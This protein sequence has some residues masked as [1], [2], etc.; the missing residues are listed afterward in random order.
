VIPDQPFEIRGVKI[1]LFNLFGGYADLL[2]G[3]LNTSVYTPWRDVIQQIK[4]DGANN[5]MLIVS[6][7]VMRNAT[8][9]DFDLSLQYN[10]EL[11]AVRAIAE[12]VKANGM[13]VT[14]STFANVANV[15]SGDPGNAGQDRPYPLDPQTWLSHYGDSIL[16][17]ARFAEAVGASSFVPFGDETQHLFR[18]TSLTDGWLTLIDDIRQVFSGTLSTY[19]WTP[20][21]GDSLS[22]IP[23]DVIDQLDY[24][25]IGFFPT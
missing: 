16:R 17:W 22:S 14:I 23:R 21:S 19:W 20:G 18:D 10:P 11:D 9:S 1:P 8:D 7:G 4:A 6:A 25:G 12:L 3:T 24:L 2:G 5:V 15:I 13:S